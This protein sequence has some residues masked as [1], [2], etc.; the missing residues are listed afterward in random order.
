MHCLVIVFGLEAEASQHQAHDVN[1]FLS[2]T[3]ESVEFVI[4]ILYIKSNF[5]LVAF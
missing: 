4:N 3:I 1:G 2:D 5:F